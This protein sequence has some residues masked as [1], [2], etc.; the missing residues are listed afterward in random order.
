VNSNG[1][2]LSLVKFRSY[3]PGATTFTKAGVYPRTECAFRIR[4]NGRDSTSWRPLFF[5]ISDATGNHWRAWRDSLLEGV[6]ETEVRAGFLGALWP[7]EEAWKVR[8]EFKQVAE[9]PANDLLR[10]ESIPI[11]G[12]EEILQPQSSYEVNGATVDVAA[13]IGANVAWDRVT[14]LN[15]HRLRD[16]FTALV[17]GKILSQGRRLTFVDATDEH[18]KRLKLEGTFSDPSQIP[19]QNPDLLPYSFNF[20]APPDAHELT[21]VLAVSQSRFVEFLA[22]PEQVREDGTVPRN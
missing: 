15:P 13:I 17:K 9:F 2:E 16:C 21:L 18:G 20:R 1:L 10:I 12:P 14:R 19:G 8:V 6:D 11:P 22:K 4:E 7:D 5:E 3:Q